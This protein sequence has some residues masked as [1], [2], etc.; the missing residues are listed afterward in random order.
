[1]YALVLVS[2]IFKISHVHE[3]MVVSGVRVGV[4]A[5]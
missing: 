2:Y 4:R 5:S 1:M 3:S